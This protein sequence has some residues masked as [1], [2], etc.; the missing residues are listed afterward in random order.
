MV[1]KA[2]VEPKTVQGILRQSS[3]DNLLNGFVGTAV[4]DSS[5]PALLLRRK[6]NRHVFLLRGLVIFRVGK[7]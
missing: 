6:M 7:K 3:L 2:K 1:N 4:K 5:K